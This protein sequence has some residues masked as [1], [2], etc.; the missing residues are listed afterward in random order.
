MYL[1]K[2]ASSPRAVRFKNEAQKANV[3]DRAFSMSLD[4]PFGKWDLIHFHGRHA[5]E[6]QTERERLTHLVKKVE[7]KRGTSSHQENPFIILCD[8]N[9]DEDHGACYGFRL[10]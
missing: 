1:P 5:L 6:R 10:V 2:K 9:T 8:R 4:I 3:L 7:S